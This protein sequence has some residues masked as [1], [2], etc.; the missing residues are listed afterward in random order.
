MAL[1]ISNPTIKWNGESLSILPNSLSYKL[2]K[3]DR[4]VRAISA[5]GGSVQAVITVDAETKKSMLKFSLA[6]TADAADK[7]A[8]MMQLSESAEGNSFEI[9]DSQLQVAFSGMALVSEPE[10]PLSQDGAI[11]LEFEGPPAEQGGVF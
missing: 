6:N 8:S 1:G 9:A 3:G 5:G 10:I 7:V 4:N 11:E 2:G